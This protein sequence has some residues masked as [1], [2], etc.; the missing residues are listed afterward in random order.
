MKDSLPAAELILR[1]ENILMTKEQAKDLG[2]APG[3]YVKFCIID[4]GS[5]MSNEISKKVFDP[6]FTT[7]GD[8]GTG[9]GLSQVFGFVQRSG[10]SITV[11]SS[12][13]S[14]SQFTLYFPE[15]IAEYKAE[16]VPIEIEMR[17]L[18][19]TETILIVDDELALSQLAAELLQTE[20]YSVFL[21]DS[22]S[23]AL[24]ILE[25]EHIDLVLSDVL[26]PGL[27]GYQL[28]TKIQESYPKAKIQLVSGFSEEK[29]DGFIEEK[30]QKSLIN[31]PYQRIELLRS[32]RTLLDS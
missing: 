4:N 27:D 30:L 28:A 12:P 25:K 23:S 7:K 31:K 20:G 29:N 10:G 19:G 14:G 3:S 1:T 6:F 21:A 24:G 9:L 16:P 8:E 2:L 17:R 5:G 11:K 15:Y 32:V 18:Q 22:G 13:G 26:M